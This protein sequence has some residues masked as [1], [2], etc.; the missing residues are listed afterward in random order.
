MYL[1]YGRPAYRPGG[2]ARTEIHRDLRPVFFLFDAELIDQ[3]HSVY[4][5]DTGA[6]HRGLFD[7]QLSGITLCQ[8]NCQTI[9]FAAQRV[10][11]RFFRSNFNYFFGRAT[12][13]LIPPATNPVADAFHKL[14]TAPGTRDHD[15]RCLT[16]EVQRP[17]SLP[18]PGRLRALLLPDDVAAEM[19]ARVQLFESNGVDVQIYHPQAMSNPSR[20][21]EQQ[22]ERIAKMQ[23]IQ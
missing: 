10:V 11:A 3:Y 4:P 22:F 20:I 17:T 9:E 8:L 16:V 19:A 13:L 18:L 12:T 6:H 5:C 15:D 21:V 23:D 7:A 1:F 2:F 14:L